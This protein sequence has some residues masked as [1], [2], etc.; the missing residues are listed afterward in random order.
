[1]TDQTE[2]TQETT[3]LQPIRTGY[4]FITDNAAPLALIAAGAGL[5]AM[6]TVNGGDNRATHTVETV[7][8]RAR[9][10]AAQAAH[11]AEAGAETA[12]QTVRHG[13]ERVREGVG[14][15]VV[16]SRETVR[17]HPMATGLAA[18]A[19]GAGAVALMPRL[20]GRGQSR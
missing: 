2:T 1:M 16:R 8:T 14:E 17:E 9:D 10:A 12:G 19:V 5:L 4:E 18:A 11:R 20:V 7:R 3:T 6:R 15:G 13:A